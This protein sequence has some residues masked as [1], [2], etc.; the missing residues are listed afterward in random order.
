MILLLTE[1]ANEEQ[2]I[3]VAKMY[4]G[5]TKVV[6][7]IKRNV[8]AAGGEYHIDCEQVLIADGSIQSDLWC[9]GY[10]F[11]SKEVDFMGLTNYK[12]AVDHLSYE[13]TNPNIRVQVEK[14]IKKVFGS[15]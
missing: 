9:G 6:V 14:V 7:D 2:L 10:R 1:K 11:E 15:E 8:L 12:P 5:Y 4:P 13:M 3:D